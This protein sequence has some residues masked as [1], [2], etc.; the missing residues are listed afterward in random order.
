MLDQQHDQ[1]RCRLVHGERT[2]GRQQLDDDHVPGG[3]RGAAARPPSA[4]ARRRRR[5]A[6]TATSAPTARRSPCRRRS[7]RDLRRERPDVRERLG[8]DHLPRR[9]APNVPV[10]SLH[11]ADRHRGQRLARRSCAARTTPATCRCSPAPRL[12][13]ER[14]Q[15]LD[16]HH[17]PAAPITTGPTPVAS[18]RR[19]RRPVGQQLDLDLLPGAGDDRPTGVRRAR[20]SRELGNSWTATICGTNNTSNVAVSA[21]R[22]RGHVGQR[23]DHD[24]LQ[25]QQQQQRAGRELHAA[26]RDLANSWVTVTCPAPVVTT[27]VPVA[28]CSPDRFPTPATATRRGPARTTTSSTFP[29]AAAWQAAPDAGNSWTTTTCPVLTPGPTASHSC[30]AA[31]GSAGNNWMTTTCSNGNTSNVPVV[32]CIAGRRRLANNYM[33]TTCATNNTTDVAVASCSG[34]SATAATTTRRRPARDDNTTE[35]A[36]APRARPA[37]PTAAN[38]W[39]TTTCP[40]INVGPI[41]AAACTPSGPGA[42]NGWTTTTCPWAVTIGPTPVARARPLRRPRQQL[43]A[44]AQRARHPPVPTVVQLRPGA[45]GPGNNYTTTT[46]TPAGGKQLATTTTRVQQLQR[47]RRRAIVGRHRRH[48]VTGP[49]HRAPATRPGREPPLPPDGRRRL[50][51]PPTRSP[52]RRARL[53]V[54]DR[55]EHRRSAQRQFAGRRR[56]VL[57]HHRPAHAARTSRAARTTTATTC[58]PWA[59]AP[60]TTGVRWQHM[61]TFSIALG[62]SGTL[63]YRSDYRTAATGDFA[64]IR[65]GARNWPLWPDPALDYTQPR[66]PTTTRARSTTSGTRR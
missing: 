56:A 5:R 28:R 14:G 39:T 32:A 64:D 9:S 24:H 1:R 40:V 6:P 19:R 46:C 53:A 23:L 51:P 38:G 15:Q 59:R 45:A 34:G 60:R 33:T 61:T 37:A 13:G 21:C 41:G 3:D 31:T 16:H 20:T 8:H 10:A 35:R 54:H 4:P 65:T 52:I 57:L 11:A 22:H 43:L 49:R 7:R 2:D 17:L 63:Q 42:G 62:V 44:R 58:R 36:G 66:R 50:E 30:T 47:E 26:D 27:N 12:A 29:R 18:S 25:Q 55:Q 48:H